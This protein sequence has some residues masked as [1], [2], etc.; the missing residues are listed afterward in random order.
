[1][2]EDYTKTVNDEFR[3]LSM[4]AYYGSGADN[5]TTTPYFVTYKSTV[6]GNRMPSWRTRI[7]EGKSATT[8]MVGTKKQVLEWTPG[9]Y[10]LV[11]TNKVSTKLWTEQYY[12][13]GAW[14]YPS[15]FL[16]FPSYTASGETAA[17][18]IAKSKFVKRAIQAQTT[19]QVGVSGGEFRETLRFIRSP[20]RGLRDSLHDY[21]RLV[22]KR[23]RERRYVK[24][25]NLDKK[26]RETLLNR[27]VAGTWLEAQLAINPLMGEVKSGAEALARIIT[28]V[29]RERVP[30]NA[31]GE[32]VTYDK[33]FNPAGAWSV[34][35]FRVYIETVY[36]NQVIY[37]GAVRVAHPDKDP[38]KSKLQVLGL[39]PKDFV[40]TI[41]ELIP[42]S[43][44]M[45]YVA[46]IDDIISAACF[47]RS[48]LAWVARTTR[49]EA[50]RTV[51]LVYDAK[52]RELS[53]GLDPS[54]GEKIIT[55][56]FSTPRSVLLSSRVERARYEGS[57]VP[58]LTFNVPNSAK[59]WAN[60]GSLLLV[61]K[62]TIEALR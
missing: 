27:M 51:T 54:L 28:K 23:A 17:D 45:D 26:V 7:A 47:A 12:K 40:P 11:Y 44:L 43:F 46:N 10:A 36:K 35:K 41:W 62:R 1:M 58:D 9:E 15:E 19:F 59:K 48:N 24:R 3:F 30:I 61:Q 5:K 8:Y 6:T 42:G 53:L 33:S 14:L 38:I 56:R 49:R 20:L 16:V 55:H 34:E 60:F 29:E 25:R 13:T 50:V 52:A 18:N 21:M 22:K 32:Y 37:R 4:L 31:V 2:S 39:M 57:L